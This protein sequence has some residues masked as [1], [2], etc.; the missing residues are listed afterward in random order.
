MRRHA[1][2]LAL[3]AG[4][5]CMA[6]GEFL[7]PV[8][9]RAAAVRMPDGTLAYMRAD[10]GAWVLVLGYGAG[11]VLVIAA[12]VMTMRRW[13]RRGGAPDGDG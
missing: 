8:A 3:A 11:F 2:V 4:L 10:P 12:G 9:R 5:V 1:D 13:R 7:Y 6:A